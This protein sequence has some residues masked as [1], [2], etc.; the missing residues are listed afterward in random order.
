MV[1]EFLVCVVLCF[2]INFVSF[3]FINEMIENFVLV[4]YEKVCFVV[5]EV[6]EVVR[7]VK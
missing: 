2:V 5:E 4:L 1:W 6:V 3:V 7:V